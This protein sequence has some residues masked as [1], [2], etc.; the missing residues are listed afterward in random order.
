[1]VR[2]GRPWWRQAGGRPPSLNPATRVWVLRVTFTLGGALFLAIDALRLH[3]TNHES[4][5]TAV[6][7]ATGQTVVV[8]P[9]VWWLVDWTTRRR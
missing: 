5:Q 3:Y 2:D 8:V 6:L 4:W 7:V 9:A 1:M